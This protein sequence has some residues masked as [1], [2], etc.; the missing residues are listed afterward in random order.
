MTTGAGRVAA[1]TY[2]ERL[3]EVPDMLVLGKGLSA[4]YFPLA[5][6]VVA[7]DVYDALA[8]PPIRLGFPNGSTTDGHPIGAA[9]GLAVLDI[10]TTDG[11]LPAVRRRGAELVEMLDA[12]SQVDPRIGAV[13]GVG[14][15]LGVELRDADGELWSLRDVHDL[16]GVCREHGL[17]TSYA[18]GVMPLLPHLTVS[19]DDCRELVERFAKAVAAYRS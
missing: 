19:T 8:D 5:A 10:L 7:S 11:F 13:R 9:A 1:M 4:G 12:A 2:I 17:L 18:S 15:M 14:M 16:R 3:S 6:L